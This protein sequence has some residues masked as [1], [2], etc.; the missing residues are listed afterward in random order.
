[1]TDIIIIT[2]AWLSSLVLT[3]ILRSYALKSSLLD[4]PNDR[5][6]HTIPTP[7]GGGLAIVITFLLAVLFFYFSGRI[8]D[9]VFWA[10]S[11]GGGLVAAIGLVDDRG[12]VSARL[13]LLV[14]FGAAGLALYC[15]GGV[16]GVSVAGSFWLPGWLLNLAGLIFMVWVLNLFNFMDGIDGIA[17]IEVISVAAGVAGIIFLSVGKNPEIILLL[18]LAAS[19]LGFLVWNWPP[20]KIFMGDAGSGFLGFILAVLAI[21]TTSLHLVSLWSWLI[22]FGVFLVD[23]TV[24]LLSRIYRRERWY[25]AHC[26]HAYQCAARY[27]ESHKKVTLGVLAINLF[28]LLPLAWYAN[29]HPEDGFFVMVISFLPLLILVIKFRSL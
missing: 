3:G 14:H 24:T 13:R 4:I 8:P 23:A 18:L 10:L 2:L 29:L 19:C 5:S 22:L 16:P 17:S 27:F 6:S 28:W 1:M 25:A 26:S 12:H 20:A 7:R 11:V 15:L 21:Y 9:N